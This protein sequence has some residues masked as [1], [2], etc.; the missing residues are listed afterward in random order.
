MPSFVVSALS[1]SPPVGRVRGTVGFGAARD[2]GAG[3]ERDDTA[4]APPPPGLGA[5]RGTGR[6]GTSGI[7]N[8]VCLTKSHAQNK[9]RTVIEV[10]FLQKNCSVPL[11]AP[12]LSLCSRFSLITASVHRQV[13]RHVTRHSRAQACARLRW[14]S[15]RC[16]AVYCRCTFA[17][18]KGQAGRVAQQ[19]PKGAA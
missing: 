7:V 2:A 3:G 19:V 18:E 12:L 10:S 9:T 15:H 1:A 13:T 5:G 6:R 8:F 4:G 11:H 17:V 14:W 16:S